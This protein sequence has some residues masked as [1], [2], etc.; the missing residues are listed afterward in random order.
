MRQKPGQNEI[1]LS[2]TG[3]LIGGKEKPSVSKN[4]GESVGGTQ[5][6]RT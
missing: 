4:S 1:I 3:Q 2:M 5:Q 6:S